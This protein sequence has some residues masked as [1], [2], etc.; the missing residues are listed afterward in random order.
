M[1]VLKYYNNP[2]VLRC[3]KVTK[4]LNYGKIVLT[5]EFKMNKKIIVILSIFV[6]LVMGFGVF[7]TESNKSVPEKSDTPTCEIDFTEPKKKPIKQEPVVLLTNLVNPLAVVKSPCSYVGK[8]INVSAR[9]NKFST[10]GLD[11]KP[12]MRS[13]ESHISFLIF[14]PDTNKNIPL[15]EMKLFVK[16]NL[17]EKYIELKEGDTIQFSGVVFSDA[18]GDV[19]VD[20]DKLDKLNK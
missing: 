3:K 4:S 9:F 16:R 15:S 18:L 2:L 12:A 5:G 7:A 10:L 13:S 6:M 20:V 11:Y 17:A 8:R 14:R 1:F 19:W